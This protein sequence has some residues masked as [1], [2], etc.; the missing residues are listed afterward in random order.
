MQLASRNRREAFVH[1]LKYPVSDKAR[2][3]ALRA[4]KQEVVQLRLRMP[5]RKIAGPV[6]P[7]IE[8]LAQHHVGGGLNVVVE[9]GIDSS[10]GDISELADT[11]I[12]PGSVLGDVEL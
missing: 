10:F 8:N 1:A 4:V 7:V 6:A 11:G 2:A 9:N 5:V 12:T 3:E